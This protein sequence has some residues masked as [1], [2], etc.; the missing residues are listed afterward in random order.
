MGAIPLEST[1]ARRP[2]WPQ[3][4]VC[5]I[6]ASFMAFPLTLLW[7]VPAVW[8]GAM[9]VVTDDVAGHGWPWRIDGPWAFLADVGPLL[10][11][12]YTL[13]WAFEV[14]LGR[15]NGTRRQPSHVLAVVAA[16]AGWVTVAAPS[17][18][19]LLPLD[20][21]LVFLVV[22]IT[23][24]KVRHRPGLTLT[25]RGIVVSAAAVAVLAAL[26]VSY[27]VLH[28][29]SAGWDPHGGPQNAVTI[30][31]HNE[32]RLPARVQSVSAGGSEVRRADDRPLAGSPVVRVESL[33]L[34][35]TFARPMCGEPF[36]HL[37]V[38]LTVAGRDVR[39]RVWLDTRAEP[40]CS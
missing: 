19:G 26:S 18:A 30:F 28:P 37:D 4:L 27:G 9:P 34:L 15:F 25:R 21:V 40:P 29:L 13:A 11:C 12:G 33:D 31:L 10:L 36:E 38:R 3:T 14:L 2:S 23:A 7:M 22:L 6:G 16:I 35:V 24:H 8:S 17:R 32:G 1:E 20:G 39:Q 5:L